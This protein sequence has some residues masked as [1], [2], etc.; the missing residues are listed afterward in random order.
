[1]QSKTATAPWF[2][3]LHR[4]AGEGQMKQPGLPGVHYSLKK[5]ARR[6]ATTSAYWLGTQGA[7]PRRLRRDSRGTSLLLRRLC[8]NRTTVAPTLPT[9][10]WRI[11]ADCR[12]LG[13]VRQAGWKGISFVISDRSA[14]RVVPCYGLHPSSAV[15]TCS[16]GSPRCCPSFNKSYRQCYSGFKCLFGTAGVCSYSD[17]GLDRGRQPRFLRSECDAYSRLS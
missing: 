2:K 13:N 6:V 11:V 8:C 17:D 5:R 16:S 12:F 3:R 14:L 4:A 9:P 15:H 10:L 1:M 7:R